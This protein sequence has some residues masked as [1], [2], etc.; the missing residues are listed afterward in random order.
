MSATDVQIGTSASRRQRIGDLEVSEVVFGP[1]TRLAWHYHPHTCLAVV[2]DGGVRK[3]FAR[4]EEDA[5]EGTVIEMPAEEFHEDLFADSGARL[6]VVESDADPGTLR[7]FR[8]WRAAH[9]AHTMSCELAR[10]D[11]FTPL[12]LE[13]LALELRAVVG[14][15]RQVDGREPRLDAVRAM[16]ARDLS[17]PPSLSQIAR[18]VGLHPSHLARIFRARYGESIG[19]HARRTRLEWG[20]RRLVSSDEPLASIAARAGFADQSHFTRAFK[21]QYGVTPG[22]YR[23]AHR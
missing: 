18:Q 13:G 10:P 12:A 9:L 3:V 11:A 15:H 23:L 22:R 2:V 8:D 4:R 1:R 17:C 6:V 19:E 20:A 7:S 16:L 14:R 21:R 5:G